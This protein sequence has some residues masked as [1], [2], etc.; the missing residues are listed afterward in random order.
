[1]SLYSEVVITYI[2]LNLI[3]I[4]ALISWMARLPLTW[5]HWLTWKACKRVDYWFLTHG[6][7]QPKTDIYRIISL[8]ASTQALNY[9]RPQS[10]LFFIEKPKKPRNRDQWNF[11]LLNREL[12]PNPMP[13]L[14][15]DIP[16]DCPIASAI[17]QAM[18]KATGL[19]RN[20]CG[21]N[22]VVCSTTRVTHL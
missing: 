11:V 13:D 6:S 3:E 21:S 1:M 22:G 9:W 16:D 8:P 2:R 5:G 18:G 20:C 17:W 14:P 10:I 12:R 19:P 4:Y 7:M 15:F